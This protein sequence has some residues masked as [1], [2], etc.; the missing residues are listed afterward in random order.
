LP[1]FPLFS[2]SAGPRHRIGVAA[3]LAV[4]V[5]AGA[6][7]VALAGTDAGSSNG[8]V[9]GQPT[10]P[11]QHVVIIS[12]ENR[13][14]DE[15][16]GKFPGADGAT[17]AMKHDGTVVPLAQTPDPM[18][19]DI[20]HDNQMFNI[21]YDG[22][23]NDGFDQEQGAYSDTGQPLALSQMSE[24]Q[25][26]NYWKY[27]S[28]YG[29]GD[30]VFS[31]WKGVSFGNNLFLMAGQSGEFEASQNNRFAWDIPHPPSGPNLH[32]WWGCDDPAGS[33]VTMRNFNNGNKSTMFPCWNYEGM[34]N[35]LADNG[36][37]WKIYSDRGAT[38]N[39]HNAAD[40]LTPIRYNSSLWENIVPLSNF[41][42][43]AIQGNLPSVSW[44]VASQSEHAPFTS[45]DGMNQSTA[46]LD[47]IMKGPEWK[48]TA[49]FIV[50]DEWGGFYDHVPP[51]QVDSISY[52][53][54]V[55]FLAISPW[56]RF[57]ST[58]GG[59]YISHNFSSQSS[60]LKFISDNW[61]V[62]YVTPHVADPTLSDLMDYFD[63]THAD[64]PKPQRML[65]GPMTCPTLSAAQRR[66]AAT[67]DPD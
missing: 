65:L 26:P 15:Y 42:S 29:L 21:A 38:A 57:G 28:R 20:G 12:K 45:C 59:G 56:V 6:A 18:P 13:S 1:A 11:I 61:D 16:F 41:R 55:P 32:T 43:D 52:G 17:T 10:T 7:T 62:P 2:S 54:R 67:E 14:F 8:S 51:P 64:P 35:I 47:A 4:A 5:V 39:I 40:A 60:I 46:E 49:V 3:L 24:S 36:V 53:F 58:K 19:N 27:A 37:S 63:F 50:W 33:Y 48:S 30:A 9:P 66:L 31:D 44:V 23:K 22:G 25:I 34:P